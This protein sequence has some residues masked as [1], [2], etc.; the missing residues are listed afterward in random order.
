MSTDDGNFSFGS[1]LIATLAGS[2]VR[3]L[4]AAEAGN[5]VAEHI[6]P[7]SHVNDFIGAGF[8]FVV[9]AWSF[10]RKIQTHKVI[11]NLQ[12]PTLNKGS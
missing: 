5:L 10:Y 7:A 6:L 1:G 3:T 4:L 11:Q 8:F 9:L 12:P 2:T